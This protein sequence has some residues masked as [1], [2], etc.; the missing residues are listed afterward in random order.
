MSK[1][2]NRAMTT[3]QVASQKYVDAFLDVMDKDM[4]ALCYE[5]SSLVSMWLINEMTADG[6]TFEEAARKLA[7]NFMLVNH[8]KQMR[9]MGEQLESRSDEEKVMGSL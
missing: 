1:S 8:C 5:Y 3:E 4:T 6:V 7:S 9:I 2:Q